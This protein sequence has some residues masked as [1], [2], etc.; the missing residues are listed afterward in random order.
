[1]A[2][3]PR[4]FVAATQHPDKVSGHM[5]HVVSGRNPSLQGFLDS[6]GG[7]SL[8]PFRELTASEYAQYDAGNTTFNKIKDHGG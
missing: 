5:L 2:H 1:M 8:G 7:S 4:I 6:N 3:E